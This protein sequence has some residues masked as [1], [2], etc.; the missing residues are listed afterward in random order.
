VNIHFSCPVCERSGRIE[1]PSSGP[2]QCPS[3]DHLLPVA[4][5]GEERVSTCAVCGNTE[6]Y[7]QKDFPH[8]LGMT[9][10]VVACLGSIV[11]YYLHRPWW[12]WAI[13][14]GSA[15]FDGLLYLW[16]RDV[17]V[18]YRCGAKYRGFPTN[19]EHQPFALEIGERYRQEKMRRQQLKRTTGDV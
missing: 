11:P 7:K 3:C 18:C 8:W 15:A 19:P 13:L 4:A 6:I 14:L 1:P 10:L 5:S 16:V 17:S 9:I 12:T 2:W